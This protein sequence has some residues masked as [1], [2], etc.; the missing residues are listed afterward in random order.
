[1][2]KGPENTSTHETHQKSLLWA[3]LFMLMGG[4][5]AVGLQHLLGR[6]RENSSHGHSYDG[7]TSAQRLQVLLG[8]SDLPLTEQ[9]LEQL[10][11]LLKRSHASDSLH[12]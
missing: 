10:R 6:R 3:T 9:E 5:G 11:M 12:Y 2:S 1:M 8:Q 4:L 7:L